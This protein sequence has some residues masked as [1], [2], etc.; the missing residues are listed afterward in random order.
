MSK[1]R[2]IDWLLVPGPPIL[3]AMCYPGDRVEDEPVCYPPNVVAGILA[4]LAGVT[5]TCAGDGDWWKW[6]A[7][8]EGRLDIFELNMTLFDT[9]PPLWG[10]CEL[11]GVTNAQET[12]HLWRNVAAALPGTY[13]HSSEAVLYTLEGFMR[14]F[15]VI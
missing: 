9:E 11:I 6:R 2:N 13:L 1:F 14:A 8:Y 7:V 15:A 10:G 3:P 5:V 4:G 12:L